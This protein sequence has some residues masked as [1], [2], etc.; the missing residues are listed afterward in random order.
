MAKSLRLLISLIGLSFLLSS[1]SV[2]WASKEISVEGEHLVY[3]EAE[4][5]ARAEGDVRLSYAD[6][7][8][9]TAFLE[10]DT[11]RQIVKASSDGKTPVTFLW[12]GQRFEGE[13]VE[14]DFN[15]GRGLI[16]NAGGRVDHLILSG[17]D[18]E[19]LPVDEALRR[20]VV[21]AKQAKG[22]E[23]GEVVG[24]WQHVSVTT[25]NEPRPHYRLTTKKLIVIPGERV[26]IKQPRVYIGE[27]LLFTYP[28]DYIVSAR[29]ASGVFLPLPRYDGTKGVG[30]GI[31][32]P[33]SWSSGQAEIALVAWSKIDPEGS[34]TLTQRLGDDASFFLESSY[35]YSEV[36]DENRW[37]PRWGLRSEKSGWFTEVLWSQRESVEIDDVAGEKRY[38]GTLWRDPQV[39]VEGPWW[40][41]AAS[42]GWWRL[43]GSWG[44]YGEEGLTTERRG[45]GLDFYGEGASTAAFRPF[46]RAT[47]WYYDYDDSDS[48]SQKTTDLA[49]GFDWSAGS[50]RLRSTY[51]RRWVDGTSPMKWDRYDETETV[52]Q[53]VTLPV[54]DQW[55][56]SLR[57]G[58]DL[59]DHNLDEMLY[60]LRYEVDCLAWELTVRD[61]RIRGDDWAGLRLIIK[62]Y[63][64]SPLQFQEKEIDEPGARPA[65]I[66][67]NS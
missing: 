25:C 51:V 55:E 28:F 37:R 58:W 36:D 34:L 59:R 21:T 62:A 41:D 24:W 27:K 61:D 11:E 13:S 38:K 32:G 48:E 47:Y 64:E 31:S 43:L 29:R 44:R 1:G 2:A 67:K 8:M 66:P 63:P 5:V 45:A 4:G 9:R 56:L 30:L 65:S 7:Q 23:R 52:Y 49:F 12:R 54:S 10:M 17:E 19:V 57:G 3:E 53:R 35:S 42:G 6:M 15:S 33:L 22:L 26:I 18:L 46:W 39:T 50:L 14:Y 40:S 20:G 60:Q 16:R